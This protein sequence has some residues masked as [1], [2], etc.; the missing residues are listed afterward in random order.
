MKEFLVS[1]RATGHG[2]PDQLQFS[3]QCKILFQIACALSFLSDKNLVHRDIAARNCLVGPGLIIK[4]ADFGLARGTGSDLYYRKLGG[5]MP[6]RW[7]PPEAIFD[8]KYSVRSDVWSFGVIIWEVFTF[9]QMPFYGRSNEEVLEESKEG[10]HLPLPNGCPQTVCDIM[11][12]CWEQD[13]HKRV[14]AGE[15]VQ[16]FCTL[17]SHSKTSSNV[18]LSSLSEFASIV[19]SDRAQHKNEYIPEDLVPESYRNSRLGSLVVHRTAEEV[20]W[21]TEN[22][23]DMDHPNSMQSVHYMNKAAGKV[24]KLE[25]SEVD[26]QSHNNQNSDADSTSTRSED[27]EKDSAVYLPSPYNVDSPFND[28]ALFDGEL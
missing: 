13:A 28:S 25:I 26:C 3:D 16:L 15:L 7:M 11:E 6:I 5:T 2:Q 20:M 24:S 12:W 21:V 23:D 9:G 4:L 17:M 14:T 1:K 19:P 22:G 10:R 18:P 27:H 8:G